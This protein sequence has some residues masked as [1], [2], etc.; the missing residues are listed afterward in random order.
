MANSYAVG[1]GRVGGDG[2]YSFGTNALFDADVLNTLR[3]KSIS[4]ISLELTINGTLYAKRNDDPYYDTYLISYKLNGTGSTESS[5]DAW[6][7]SDADSTAAAVSRI[8]QINSG[9]DSTITG[10]NTVTFDLTG[11]SVPKYGYVFRPV[12][13]LTSTI[14]VTAAVLTIITDEPDSSTI[15]ADDG[16]MGSPLTISISREDAAFV[17]TITY[18]FGEQTGTIVERTSAA[19]VTWTPPASLALEIMDRRSDVCTLTVT[20]YD[21]DT[22]L[23]ASSINIVLTTTAKVTIDAVSLT[24]TVSG[25]A[26]KIGAY[27]QSKSKV[28]V[29]VS[30]DATTA[31][32][33]SVTAYRI[34]ING[35]T[36][37]VNN[38]VTDAITAFGT[39]PYS[40]QITDSRGY[41]DTYQGTYNVLQYNTP[42]L[43][44]TAE[45][46]ES[47]PEDVDVD[48]TVQIS[49]LGN[50]NDKRIEFY[51]KEI[52]AQ[53]FVNDGTVTPPQYVGSGTYT[54]NDTDMAVTNI[55]ELRVSDYFET[56]IF[57]IQVAAFGARALQ[58][59]A[60]DGTMAVGGFN[61]SDGDHHFYGHPVRF[62][63]G[64]IKV[65]NTSLT[66]SDVI[67]LLAL[68]RS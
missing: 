48:Y 22:L 36:F 60:T 28:Q 53:S 45:R 35:Q 55:I 20:T 13:M 31:Y 51:H 38:A 67:A 2:T 54:I 26:S 4:S 19:S 21:G 46:D 44:A 1:G 7:T 24:E 6:T 25:I 12:A 23:G 34:V 15:I 61:T 64:T 16:T 10:T 42:V 49:D 5:G 63:S 29:S 68:I 59:S 33:A 58:F 30:T 56:V 43:T 50:A 27:V 14:T 8:A 32:G 17:D 65:G 52:G 57:D 39:L 37:A 41:T 40:V 9:T 62:D 47:A 3:N 66:E 18:A 11:S